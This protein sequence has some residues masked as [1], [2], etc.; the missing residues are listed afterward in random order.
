[1]ARFL[2]TGG[3]GHIGSQVACQAACAG[4]TVLVYDNLSTGTRLVER[5]AELVVGDVRD[6]A[7]VEDTVR[8][9][10]PDLTMHFAAK[11][12]VPESVREPLLYYDNNVGGTISLLQ[13]LASCGTDRFIFSSTAAVYGIP[14]AIPVAEE[15]PLAPINPYGRSKMAV[16]HLLADLA[17]S[18]QLRPASLR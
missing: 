9:F 7:R 12:V 18:G 4:H 11:I 16:E 3:A 2:L 14:Q 15:A 13:A 6:R 8:R 1:M 10:A 5:W 17:A